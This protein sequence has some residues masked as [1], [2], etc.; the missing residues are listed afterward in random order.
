MFEADLTD[1]DS[2]ENFVNGCDY[3]V[4][5][6]S[7]F[8]EVDKKINEEEIMK[9]AVEGTLNVLRAAQKYGVKRVV[10]TS[11]LQTVRGKTIEDK[12]YTEADM[13]DPA[14]SFNAYGKSKIIAEMESWDFIKNQK[15]DE[16][17]IE[18]VTLH[19]GGIIGPTLLKDKP[20]TS[21]EMIKKTITG[22]YPMLPLICLSFTDVRD[23]AEMH[24]NALSC[25]PNERYIV[26]NDFCYTSDVANWIAED[27]KDSGYK[28]TKRIM[29]YLVAYFGS[30]FNA[31]LASYIGIWGKK[32]EFDNSKAKKYL[33]YNPT[34]VRDS[35][36]EMGES[37]FEQ[38]Y[39]ARK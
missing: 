17:K 12:I 35:V 21:M 10:C 27:F 8:P 26:A 22:E 16:H 14:D 36:R 7:P 39:I 31:G 32:I 37:L 28:S 5:V 23:L 11:S 15:D 13:P 33:D 25:P 3:I 19:P 29:P 4:H 30:F 1:K 20:F 24:Y 34:P 38:G 2:I 9:P 18:M 6:A